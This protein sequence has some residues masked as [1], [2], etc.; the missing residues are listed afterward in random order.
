MDGFAVLFDDVAD[1]VARLARDADGRRRPPRRHRRS[2]RRSRRGEAARIMTGSPTPTAATAIV[3]FEDTVGGLADS[4]GADHG[5]ARAARRRRAHPPPRRRRRRRRR[6]A[7]RRHR[8]SAPLQAAAAAAAGVADVVVTRLPRVAVVSTGSELVA[9]GAPLRR[10]QIPESN[11]ELLAGL[12]AE[13]GAE[14]VLRA[15]VP[16][17]GD[18]P[19]RAIAEAEALGADVVVFS[20]GVSAGAYEVVKN[21]LGDRMTFTKVADAAGQAAGLRRDRRRDA[22]VRPPRQPG[23]R[24]RVVRG[25]RAAGAADAAG[26]HRPAPAGDPPRRGRRLAHPARPH[27]STCR[28][29]STAPTRRGGSPSRPPAAARTSPADSA[30]PRPTPSSPPRSTRSVAGDLVDV[31]LIS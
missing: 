11:S 26:P 1:A 4:L 25:V 8:R 12:A 7:P 18:G 13:A 22:A 14:V 15:T 20:G 16:D 5:R 29:R 23:E 19:R 28:S 9:P 24:R 31:M 27:A 17:D 2:T 10:G 30:A 21:T 3:P 6:A